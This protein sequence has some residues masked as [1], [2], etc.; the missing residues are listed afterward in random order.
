MASHA[1]PSPSALLGEQRRNPYV[2]PVASTD[3]RLAQQPHHWPRNAGAKRR[4]LPTLYRRSRNPRLLHSGR[5]LFPARRRPAA[6]HLRRRS[7]SLLENPLW[8][9]PPNTGPYEDRL[10]DP[11]LGGGGSVGST[12]I[13][14]A[15]ASGL[16]VA[17]VT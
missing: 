5:S 2:L 16:T 6:R 9:P 3:N 11:C 17:I 4:W 13:Q 7:W 12:V 8:P 14:L 10:N 15:S 1:S